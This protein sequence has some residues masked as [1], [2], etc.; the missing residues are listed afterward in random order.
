MPSSQT[1]YCNPS[2]KDKLI[3]T[4]GD[5]STG[6]VKQEEMQKPK[7]EHV[8][9]VI[10]SLVQDYPLDNIVVVNQAESFTL[11]RILVTICNT[12]AYCKKAKLYVLPSALSAPVD[13]LAQMREPVEYIIPHYSKAP[14][15]S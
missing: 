13:I 12:L 8:L 4:F 11:I 7:T 9:E 5:F 1:L 6:E 10:N 3:L 14:N 2:Q 15:I